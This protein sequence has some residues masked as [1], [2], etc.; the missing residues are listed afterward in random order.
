MQSAVANL[1]RGEREAALQSQLIARRA[2]WRKSAAIGGAIA[3]SFAVG[4]IIPAPWRLRGDQVAA[5]LQPPWVDAIAQYQSLYV[6][7]TVLMHTEDA[8]LSKQVLANIFTSSGIRIAVPNLSAAGLSFKR[9]QELGFGESPLLQM[10]Y[11]GSQGKPAALCVLATKD[12][13]TNSTLTSQKLHGLSVAH[14]QKGKI[15]YVFAVDA[16][17][18][19]VSET[20][21]R[22]ARDQFPVL[23]TV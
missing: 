21:Q 6:R 1:L 4:S 12:F 10:V 5:S 16:P 3:A 11:L 22:I 20:A 8:A 14:W 9:A 15:A 7:N 2:W 13:A 17:L 18:T 19:E 23:I